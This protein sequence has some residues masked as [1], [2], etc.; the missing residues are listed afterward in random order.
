MWF[1]KFLPM[2]VLLCFVGNAHAMWS[3]VETEHFQIHFRPSS[4]QYACRTA[5]IAEEVHEKLVLELGYS[6]QERTHIILYDDTDLANGY[7]NTFLFNAIGINLVYPAASESIDVGT[8]E[9]LRYVLLHEYTHVLQMDMATERLLLLRSIFG[10]M[11]L[12]A[13]PNSAMPLWLLEGYAIYQETKHT[14]GGRASGSVYDMYMRAA[15]L[16]GRIPS[17]GDASGAY[18]LDEW[19]QG[20]IPYLFGSGFTTYLAERFGDDII[21]NVSWES[22]SNPFTDI[23]RI[24]AKVTGVDLECL[25]EDWL[26]ELRQYY[27]EQAGQISAQG[28]TL[29]QKLT[30]HGYRVGH[31]KYS[32]DGKDIAYVVQGQLMPA[33]RLFAV[34]GAHDRQLVTGYIGVTGDYCWSPDGARLVYAKLDYHD[35]TELV[36]DLYVFDRHTGKEQRLTFGERADGPAWRPGTDEITYIARQ[37][38][39]TELMTY[40]FGSQM[41]SPLLRMDESVQIAKASWS[42]QGDLLLLSLWSYGAG[43]DIYEY[44]PTAKSLRPITTDS[45]RDLD[46]AWT[47]DGRYVIY[48]SDRGGIFNLYA[49]D[50]FTEETWQ[51]T[52][53]LY[54]AFGPTI[55]PDGRYITYVG[56]SA[57]GY[58]LFTIPFM[59]REWLRVDVNNEQVNVL[60]QGG[61]LIG[62]Q[63]LPGKVTD[64]PVL[65]YNP[66]ESLSP[67]FMY[68]RFALHNGGISLG[69]ATAGMDALGE[70]NYYVDCT[71][72]GVNELSFNFDYEHK[73][74]SF[75]RAPVFSL[76]LSRVGVS[77]QNRAGGIQLELAVPIS[78]RLL[79]DTTAKAGYRAAGL[80]GADLEIK[81]S[82]LY[83]MLAS[84]WFSG[85][86]QHLAYNDL[87][88]QGS[89]VNRLDAT[90]LALS[91]Q[92]LKQ[93]KL[94]MDTTLAFSAQGA[95]SPS[96]GVFS[97][98]GFYGGGGL[99]LRG[100]PTDQFS[101]SK[102]VLLTGEY[103]RKL[104]DFRQGI[105][106]RLTGTLFVEGGTAWDSSS[107][108]GLHP[109]IGGELVWQTVYQYLYKNTT[110]V[111]VAVGMEA[112]APFQVYIRSGFAF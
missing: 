47:P 40:S 15:L 60:L 57:Q 45:S 90:Y 87:L 21:A 73:L 30:N 39:K 29:A 82:T 68:P 20:T 17:L 53:L 95:Y 12:I 6:P 77:K 75:A 10:K 105:F 59:S 112:S 103:R 34:D 22:A 72:G 3:T 14:T 85:R 104:V 18:T 56:Y 13:H 74:T 76:G 23:G 111:G 27:V 1:R 84:R 67:K 55:S 52:N 2:I 81:M 38:Q 54:G 36:N 65:P 49:F 96:D 102:A 44:D 58:D 8:E 100:Y 35:Y 24:V 9:W 50:R 110:A 64:L 69:V 92:F 80:K 19:P 42:P 97:L 5:V 86:D 94:D 32:P 46:P 108:D 43:Y 101:G 99:A 33:L 106:D 62:K 66:W 63:A 7:A 88:V 70:R 28:L 31:P 93:I 107:F 4:Q 98:G 37:G 16:E 11:P 48:T 25:W 41:S 89:W 71:F 83:L 51:V 26:L 109:T 79:L 61:S 78:R 91:G